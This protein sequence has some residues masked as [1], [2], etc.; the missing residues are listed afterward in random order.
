MQMRKFLC[1]YRTFLILLSFLY[2]WIV[3]LFH[4]NL[5]VE[6]GESDMRTLD[7]VARIS[8]ENKEPDYTASW[9]HLN[10]SK[11]RL[12][13]LSSTTNNTEPR[14]NHSWTAESRWNYSQTI[15]PTVRT[16]TPTKVFKVCDSS[17]INI[18]LTRFREVEPGIYAYSAYLDDRTSEPAIRFMMIMLSSL[19]KT[20]IYC[21]FIAPDLRNIIVVAGVYEMC[22]N[23][24]KLFGGYMLSCDVPESLDAVCDITIASQN[25]EEDGVTLPVLS[26]SPNKQLYSFAMCIP[27]LYGKFSSNSLIEFIEFSLLLGAEHFYFYDFQ[28]SYDVQ[29]VLNYYNQRNLTTILPWHLP[30]EVM[31]SSLWY[32]GQLVMHND[33]LY[34]TMSTA[35]MV[36]IN[37]MDEYLIP[38]GARNWTQLVHSLSAENIG[39]FRFPS[40]FYDITNSRMHPSGLLTMSSMARTKTFSYVRTKVMVAPT[41]IFEVGIH[42]VSKPLDEAYKIISVHPSHAFIH[43]YRKCL[44]GYSMTC[45]EFIPDRTTFRYYDHLKDAF[46]K[47]VSDIDELYPQPE[48]QIPT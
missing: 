32:N 35:K 10:A 2:L 44:S 3:F 33:C 42:H 43:H 17:H 13:V 5:K 12:F 4:G 26:I 23:H 6:N 18:S 11:C 45:T 46:D 24:E 21:V 15:P 37:D 29:R 27:P 40:A 8:T 38:S 28:L 14:R 34:R 9:Q 19:K 48:S 36:V 16:L 25:S 31:K 20:P 47:A 30:V 7:G 41:K 22:E 1:S 39:G